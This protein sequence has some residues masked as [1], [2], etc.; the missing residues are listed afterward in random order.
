MKT[1]R[2]RSKPVLSE[3]NFR[4]VSSANGTRLRVAVAGSGPLV[5]MVHGFPESWFSW[6]HQMPAITAAGF[7]AAALDV[8]GYGGS[9]KPEAIEAYTITELAADIAA[10]I[11]ALDPSGAVLIGHDWG[12]PQVYGAALIYPEKVRAVVGLSVPAINYIDRKPSEFWARTY[13]DRLFYQTYFWQPGPA[14]AELE[15][16]PHRTIRL[17]YYALSGNRPQGVSAMVRP[18]GA[19]SLLAGLPDPDPLPPW[20]SAEDVAYYAESFASGGF[21][22]PLNR[23][24]AQDI[25]VEQLRR[26]ADRKIEQ[27]GIFIAGAVDPARS[28]IPGVDRYAD[29]VP[30]FVDCRGIHLLDGIGHWV[31]QEAPAAVNQLILDFLGTLR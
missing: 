24:R 28:M 2:S 12:A 27:P 13:P 5:L 18:A 21:R 6:R 26:Y 25:D 30:R 20:L 17:F 10:V 15:A 16:D 23:Y 3:T 19:T 7:T 29:P 9:D 11:D 31:Q 4:Y 22:G 14:E 8:R 1:D